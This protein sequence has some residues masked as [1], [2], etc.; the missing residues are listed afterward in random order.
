[1]LTDISVNCGHILKVNFLFEIV[2]E[3]DPLS[4][5]Q[6]ELVLRINLI[7]EMIHIV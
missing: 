3:V 4:S 6:I 2:V 7:A 1:M 5:S